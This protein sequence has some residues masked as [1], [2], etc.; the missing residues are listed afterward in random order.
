N[1]EQPVRDRSTQNIRDELHSYSFTQVVSGKPK[2]APIDI[3]LNLMMSMTMVLLPL[4]LLTFFQIGFLPYHSEPITWWHRGMLVIDA[5]IVWFFARHLARRGRGTK[6]DLA[7][8]W[9]GESVSKTRLRVWW[10]RRL[11]RAQW[12]L[13]RLR[14]PVRSWEFG[15]VIAVPIHSLL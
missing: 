7:D 10:L 9:R 5:G 12:A 13:R 14:L 1:K 3:A 8:W 2:G 4:L 15:R 6:V 11:G